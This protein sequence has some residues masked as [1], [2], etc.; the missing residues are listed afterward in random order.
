M[1]AAMREMHMQTITDELAVTMYDSLCA[2]YERNY[3]DLPGSAQTMISDIAIMEQSKRLYYANI[4][5]RGVMEHFQQGRQSFER[6]NKAVSMA[7]ALAEQQRKMLN[8]LKLTPTSQRV[9]AD[10]S[11][12]DF[13]SF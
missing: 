9:R 1:D 2:E 4:A 7:K 13:S 3:G 10:D 8:E 12:D 11:E 5:K 6:E